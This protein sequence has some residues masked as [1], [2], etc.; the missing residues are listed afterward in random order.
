[1]RS[2]EGWRGVIWYLGLIVAVP[3]A[4]DYSGI[5]PEQVSGN[6][7]L[8]LGDFA[9]TIQTLSVGGVTIWVVTSSLWGSARHGRSGYRVCHEAVPP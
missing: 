9:N 8:L 7:K 1:M 3:T 5:V 6:L 2:Q 4:I